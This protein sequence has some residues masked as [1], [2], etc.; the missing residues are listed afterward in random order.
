MKNARFLSF[1][2]VRVFAIDCAAFVLANL[3]SAQ[4][5]EMHLVGK[6]EK[7]TS[8]IVARRDVNGRF[9]AAIQV[10]SD[11]EGLKFQ[12]N[13]DVVGVD[14]MPGRYLV[15]LQ[16]DERILE[17]FCTGY[18]P[19]KIIFS[20]VG[21]ILKEKEVWKVTVTGEKKLAEIPI[22]ILATPEG[23]TV[24]IDDQPMGTGKNFKVS[25]GE[26]YLRLT[27]DGHRPITKQIDVSE[28]STLF[29]YT[30]EVVE[31]VMVTITSNPTGASIFIDDVDE[32]QTNKQLFKFPGE[33]NLKLIK[34]NYETI[35]E[36]I[37]VSESGKNTRTFNL[38]KTTAILTINTTPADAQIWIN[39]ELKSTKS[40]EVAPGKYRIEVKKDGWYDDNQTVTIEKGQDQSQTFSLQQMTGKLQLV[41]EPMETKVLMKQGNQQIDTWSGSKYKKDIPVGQYTMQFS[42]AG[43]GDQ[44]KTITIE[45]NK[46]DT[47]DI[48]MQKSSTVSSTL[49]AIQGD[50]DGDGSPEYVWIVP[51]KLPKTQNENNFGECE[52]E[53]NCFLVF[54]KDKIPSIKL[55]SC[56]GGIPVNE[57]DLNDDGADEVGILPSWWTSCWRGYQVYTLRNNKWK[58]V[59]KPFSTHC[60]QWEQGVDAIERDK[61]KPGYL[62]I[63]YSYHTGTDIVTLTKSVPV[64]K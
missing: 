47:L 39:G 41:V 17:I 52:G 59:V 38:V 44:T 3:I 27:L 31:P 48:K 8:E 46:T 24:V 30:L 45:E 12:S 22:N 51:P 42:A 37:T 28:T 15:F 6:P 11:L 2:L 55:E 62:I 56:I 58:F 63:R 7:I 4:T 16:P 10:V 19:L 33:Y 34:T 5:N 60:N 35:S 57:G 32:G 40:L 26:H 13:N 53:C 1:I 18:I 29:E 14:Q 9:C 49:N 25:P 21:I 61:L 54:S 20:E 43:Y 36:T 50:F 64:E 23:A